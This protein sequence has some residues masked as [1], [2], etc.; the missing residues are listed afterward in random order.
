[1]RSPPVTMRGSASP[2]TVGTRSSAVPTGPR[3]RATWCTC[4]TRPSW[5]ARCSPS[6]TCRSRRSASWRAAST[7]APPTS[8]TARTC[9]SSC[10][11]AAGA[12]RSSATGSRSIG[13][14]R[15]HV[16][17]PPGRG[18]GDR[19]RHDRA[20]QGHR[21]AGRRSEALR[22]R[23]RHRELGSSPSATTSTC[24]APSVDV[25]S[26][27]VGRR[28]G[29]RRRAG[30]VQRPRRPAPGDRSSG[31]PADASTVRRRVARAAAPRR[32]RPERRAVRPDRHPC[33]RRRHRH[34]T[35][36]SS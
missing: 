29:L 24:S 27:D 23:R 15:R 34:L 12:R 21:P 32:P 20:A 22:R 10:R 11:H 36:G 33:P 28:A 9:A 2:A 6:A 19:A 13:P 3:T 4:S 30:A 26:H 18:R 17:S 7:C 5:R 1:M 31:R 14:G 16:G 25:H 8:P 35:H